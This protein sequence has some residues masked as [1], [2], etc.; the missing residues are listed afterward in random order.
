MQNRGWSQARCTSVTH[1]R[2]TYPGHSAPGR[3]GSLVPTLSGGETMSLPLA[4]PARWTVPA[5]PPA[6]STEVTSHDPTCRGHDGAIRPQDR[7]GT[8]PPD[9][10]PAPRLPG[11]P[12]GTD[13]GRLDRRLSHA[14]SPTG[15]SGTVWP[16]FAHGFIGTALPAPVWQPSLSADRVKKRCPGKARP[17]QHS[18][19]HTLRSRTA[20]RLT[21]PAGY[22]PPAGVC[23]RAVSR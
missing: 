19:Q 17:A 8:G 18:G 2:T 16:P 11:P 14:V 7:P 1:S 6:S 15:T 10:D 21:Q 20:R 22:P 9:E 4:R 13:A 3:E 12:I 23:R 5:H